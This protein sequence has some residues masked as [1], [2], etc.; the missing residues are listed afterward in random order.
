MKKEMFV[1]ACNALRAALSSMIIVTRLSIRREE[2]RSSIPGWGI[3]IFSVCCLWKSLNLLS[4]EHTEHFCPAY[5]VCGMKL[6]IDLHV[7]P[8]RMNGA[9]TSL[10]HTSPRSG[11]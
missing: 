8:R 5:S 9:R 2:I 4:S 7:V 11:S 3:I 1:L 6:T 10:H